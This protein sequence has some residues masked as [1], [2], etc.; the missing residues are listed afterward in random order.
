MLDEHAFGLDPMPAD[1]Q[2]LFDFSEALAWIKIG[3]RAARRGWNGRDQ[4][5]F[6][7]PGS[8]FTVDRA[9][10]LG[11]YPAGE[12]VNYLQHIDMRTSAGDVVPWLASQSDLLAE[13]WYVVDVPGLPRYVKP[14]S[15]EDANGQ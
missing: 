14:S 11:I 7:V 5:I 4:F 9:P 1:Q 2:E 15:D 3:G 8:R 12:V 6:L 13:D 10:L